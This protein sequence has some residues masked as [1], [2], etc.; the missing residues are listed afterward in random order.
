MNNLVSF[1]DKKVYNLKEYVCDLESDVKKLPTDCAVGSKAFCLENEKTYM[2]NSEHTW[3]EVQYP[4][5]WKNL[6]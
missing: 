1:A 2:M 5:V 4:W 3:Q 6:T